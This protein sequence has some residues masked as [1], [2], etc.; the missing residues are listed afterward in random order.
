MPL[1]YKENFAEVKAE[2]ARN[3]NKEDNLVYGLAAVVFEREAM[4]TTYNAIA[5]L[6]GESPLPTLKS[7]PK[8]LEI[9]VL[10]AAGISVA[11]RAFLDAFPD[12]TFTAS[13]IRDRLGEQGWNWDRYTNPQATV[14]TTLVR[15]A[16]APAATVQETTTV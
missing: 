16:A 14:Y 2:L 15:L 11:I 7:V 8:N 13:A 12:E 4:Q 3:H 1:C 6:V 9:E 5:P 10:Q